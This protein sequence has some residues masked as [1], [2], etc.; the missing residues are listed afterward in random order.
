MEKANRETSEHEEEIKLKFSGMNLRIPQRKS[1]KYETFIELYK[2]ENKKWILIDETEPVGGPEPQ[3]EHQIQLNYKFEEIFRMKVEVKYID[4]EDSTSNKSDSSNGVDQSPSPS[5][6]KKGTNHFQMQNFDEE[7]MEPKIL[8]RAELDLGILI[9]ASPQELVLELEHGGIATGDVNISFSKAG[10]FKD[11]FTFELKARKVKNKEWFSKTD[12]FLII[13]RPELAYLEESDPAKI[14][15][16]VEVKRTE[17]VENDLNPDF[18][19]FTITSER[20]C[21][22]Q[23]S[24][25]LK[26]E[27]YNFKKNHKHK[28]IAKGYF[29]IDEIKAHYI[30]VKHRQRADFVIKC[31]DDK[32][33]FGGKVYVSS[34]NSSKYYSLID[35]LKSGLN[36]SLGFGIDFTGSNGDPQDARS[37]HYT[38]CGMNQY[39]KIIHLMGSM[40]SKYDMEGKV[41]AYGFGAKV[42]NFTKGVSYCFDLNCNSDKPYVKSFKKVQKKYK[43]IL[44]SLELLGPTYISEVLK[45]MLD[46]VSED[47]RE[48]LKKAGK[49]YQHVTQVRRF[50]EDGP[51]NGGGEKG[52]RK[53]SGV[54]KRESYQ[55]LDPLSKSRLTGYD[56]N[57]YD[58]IAA[59]KA[60][61]KV[62]DRLEEEEGG[63]TDSEVS[64]SLIG[65]GGELVGGIA[66]SLVTMK[67]NV[68]EMT[69]TVVGDDGESIR[70]SQVGEGI[71]SSIIMH[72]NGNFKDASPQNTQNYENGSEEGNGSKKESAYKINRMQTYTPP[73][74]A[75]MNAL[76]GA[77]AKNDK[78]YNSIEAIGQLEDA[79]VSDVRSKKKVFERTYERLD[80]RILVIITDGDVSDTEN[81][82]IQLVRANALPVSI[83]VIGVGD[84]PMEKNKKMFNSEFLKLKCEGGIIRDFISFLR[85]EDY[86]GFGKPGPKVFVRDALKNIPMQI[87]RFYKIRG[88]LPEAVLMD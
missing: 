19:E 60:L 47:Q 69:R 13:Y 30:T 41:L 33:K 38:E 61:S 51:R 77:F 66:D 42:M 26:I 79:S 44:T 35:F 84:E 4:I 1:N 85:W 3:Y 46:F 10:Q 50:N 25:L 7:D 16:W 88:V 36:I 68:T 34:F 27:I 6:N 82:L 75:S 43:S 71:D 28:L 21:K 12:P 24:T 32:N 40:L 65:A 17:Y 8:G 5:P 2:R 87:V 29:S 70:V 83:L 23:T 49:S 22:Q 48:V 58:K 11:E 39:Q 56:Q 20:L 54:R 18:R 73:P 81:T 57:A 67:G 74:M 14:R 62:S 86:N 76:P 9:G 63:F 53:G 55:D 59:M 52:S 72:A 37:L 45:A 80:Y 15:D 31:F 78:R 64:G